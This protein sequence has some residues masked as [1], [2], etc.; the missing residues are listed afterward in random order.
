M[1][2]F[3]MIARL[4]GAGR[5]SEPSAT[6]AEPKPAAAP[7]AQP[8]EP[9]TRATAAP[10]EDAP[11]P[12]A[13]SEQAASSGRATDEP[14]P[15]RPEPLETP[16]TAANAPATPATPLPAREVEAQSA[17]RPEP[18]EPTT[19]PATPASSHA[20]PTRSQRAALL[21]TG[22]GPF[23]GVPEN[24]SEELVRRIAARGLPG[25]ETLILPTEWAA[26]DALPE[27]LADA[28]KVL[29]F[30]VATG[31]RRIRYERASRPVAAEKP[32]AA[33]NGPHAPPIHSRRTRLDVTRL[34]K[35]ARRKGFPVATSGDAGAY[36]CN[37]TYGAAL[38]LKPDTLF[39]H[40][41]EPRARGPLSMAGLERHAAW[42]AKA[43]TQETK[44]AARPKPVKV[45]SRRRRPA[46]AGK[47]RPRASASS[48]PRNRPAAR[49]AGR[50][51]G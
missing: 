30:G 33:G 36:I 1:S 8:E 15:V 39:V 16:V 49:A 2:F 23:P 22:F 38:A 21:V 42:L 45:S 51:K 47:A 5:K 3:D 18:L 34:A 41:P 17:V 19:Q 6:S 10:A 37:A 44:R 40:I 4:F 11:E 20:A 31:A 7:P 12:E 43:L 24:P 9:A 14:A 46:A 32:D 48:S 26:C 25:V 13:P 29:M 50:S 27:K 28:R 35:E